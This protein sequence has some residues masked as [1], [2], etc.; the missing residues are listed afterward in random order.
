MKRILVQLDTDAQPSV[1]DAVVAVDAGVDHLFRHGNVQPESVRD[2]VYGAMFTRGLKDLCNTAVFVGGSDL[3]RAERILAEARAAFFGPMRVSLMLDCGGCNTTAAA[4]VRCA[5]REMALN[6]ASALVLG[7]T[8]PVG[9]RVARLLAKEGARVRVGSRRADRAAAVCDALRQS[10]TQGAFEGIATETAQDLARAID[11]VQVVVAAGAAG[12]TLLTEER[13]RQA[14]ALRI[15]IDLNAVPPA[16]IEGI[17]PGD[18]AVDRDGLR[19]YGALG[20]GG[21]KMKIHKAAVARL[22]ETNE[23]VL[24]VEEIYA[25]SASV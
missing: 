24:D 7:G 23:H 2:L 5:A 18:K 20:V 11:G 12:V 1:F 13:R 25:L 15:A 19:V 4:A 17:A 21:V 6:G 14:T 3:P 22:F 9:Q 16:G 8:G 10:V